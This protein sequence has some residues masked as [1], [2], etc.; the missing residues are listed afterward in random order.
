[1]KRAYQKRTSSR[2]RGNGALKEA[3]QL[4]LDPVELIRQLQ[5]SVHTFAVE[6]GRLMA[7]KLLEDEVQRSAESGMSGATSGVHHGTGTS[8]G[9][10]ASA[11][12]RW[13]SRGRGCE[14]AKNSSWIDTR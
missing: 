4:M 11:D 6:V 8:A 7:K 3:I 1:M 10:L 12:R 14:P 5:H 13:R 9:G 2:S